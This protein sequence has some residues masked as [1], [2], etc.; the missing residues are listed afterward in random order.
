MHE[1]QASMIYGVLPNASYDF[2]LFIKFYEQNIK[3]KSNSIRRNNMAIN[4]S[5]FHVY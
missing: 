5:L 4:L 2:G 3:A 1:Y